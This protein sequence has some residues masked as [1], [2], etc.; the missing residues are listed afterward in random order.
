MPLV[1]DD[2]VHAEDV[3]QSRSQKPR[4]LRPTRFSG[5]TAGGGAT[6]GA[7]GVLRSQVPRWLNE[8]ANRARV[9]A[10]DY[11]PK[12]GPRRGRG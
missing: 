10:F 6:M 3:I 11:A 8:P 7:G 5:G 9:L 1:D 4:F 12:H 2:R